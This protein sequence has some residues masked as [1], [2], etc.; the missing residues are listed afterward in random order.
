M[1]NVD[2]NRKIYAFWRQ[3][4]AY[5]CLFLSCVA[6][7]LRRLFSL[8]TMYLNLYKK[9]NTESPA[10]TLIFKTYLNSLQINSPCTVGL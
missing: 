4:V 8:K 9:K 1:D 5:I 7:F 3:G 10:L 6:L 2:D